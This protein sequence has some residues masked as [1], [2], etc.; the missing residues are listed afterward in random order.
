MNFKHLIK[1][2]TYLCTIEFQIKDNKIMIRIQSLC[3]QSRQYV[4]I[5]IIIKQQ[6]NKS[7]ILS[8]KFDSNL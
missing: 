5:N 3:K 2:G 6:Q 4:N 1:Q 8:N 7:A